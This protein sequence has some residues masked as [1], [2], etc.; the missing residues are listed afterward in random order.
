MNSVVNELNSM[1]NGTHDTNI[2]KINDIN[3]NRD[4]G[5]KNFKYTFIKLY[6]KVSL[7]F[8]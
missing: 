4:K 3:T 7:I 6:N 5:Q 8:N 2:D 1:L